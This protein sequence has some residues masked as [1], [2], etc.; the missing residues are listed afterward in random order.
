MENVWTQITLQLTKSDCNKNA[1]QDR[2]ENYTHT[3]LY[4]LLYWKKGGKQVVTHLKGIQTQ[5]T[6]K[7]TLVLNQREIRI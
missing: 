4:F 2:Q 5:S 6:V 7:R 3:P 1:K